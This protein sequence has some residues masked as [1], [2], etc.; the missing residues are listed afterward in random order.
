MSFARLIEQRQAAA[1]AATATQWERVSR[2][3]A[4]IAAKR[5]RGEKLS[6]DEW[7]FLKTGKL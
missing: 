3:K 5:E 4:R 7:Q 2:I 6:A 1:K